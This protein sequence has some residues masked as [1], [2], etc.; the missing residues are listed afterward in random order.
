ML[1]F[2]NSNHDQTACRALVWEG[3]LTDPLGIPSGTFWKQREL[4][5]LCRFLSLC[6]YICLKLGLCA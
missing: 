5:Y 2:L 1:H 3:S 4:Y 6:C